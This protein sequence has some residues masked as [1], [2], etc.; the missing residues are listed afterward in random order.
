MEKIN[1][2]DNIDKIKQDVQP[3]V[4]FNPMLHLKYILL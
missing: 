3:E 4:L 2:C 1:M